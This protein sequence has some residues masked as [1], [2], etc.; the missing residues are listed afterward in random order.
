M[1]HNGFGQ[2]GGY[3]DP[4]NQRDNSFHSVVESALNADVQA[5]ALEIALD[6]QWQYV[7]HPETGEIL[8][9]LNGNPVVERIPMEQRLAPA[10]E[11][12]NMIMGMLFRIIPGIGILALIIYGIIATIAKG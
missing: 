6:P 1:G 5:R 8:Y 12:S 9:D 11:R 10:V 4:Y 7:R 2:Y 3:S